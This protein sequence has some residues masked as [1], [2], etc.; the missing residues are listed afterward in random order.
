MKVTWFPDSQND[1]N[2]QFEGLLA[3]YDRQGKTL[4]LF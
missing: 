4:L 3:L 1:F 2:W